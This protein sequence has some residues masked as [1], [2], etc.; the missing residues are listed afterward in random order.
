M[1][2]LT[3][4]I[5]AGAAVAGL[6]A[7]GAVAAENSH[8][9]TIRLPDGSQEQIRYTGDVAPK[10]RIL[11]APRSFVAFA[12]MIDPFGPDSPFAEMD[13]ISAAMDREA[14]QLLSQAQTL[15]TGAGGLEEVDARSLPPGVSGYSFVST[16]SGGKSC[17]R[18]TQYSAPTDGRPAK[19]LTSSSGDC[20]PAKT[21]RPE[22]TSAPPAPPEQPPILTRTGYTSFG[23][24]R[25]ISD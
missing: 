17:T 15:P 4:F 7:V 16:F 1:R 14:A 24:S 5:L 2:S 10:V 22:M 23:K 6:A 12:P 9:L 21:G 19:V 3:K 18:A 8:V 20:G 11:T 13:Q 25:S